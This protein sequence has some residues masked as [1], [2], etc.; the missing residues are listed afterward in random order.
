MAV[1]T[2]GKTALPR[3]AE[4]HR[5]TPA[6]SPRAGAVVTSLLCPSK[7][8]RPQRSSFDTRKTGTLLEGLGGS[9]DRR[10]LSSRVCEEKTDPEIN[11]NFFMKEETKT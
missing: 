1:R 9:P 6:Q 4:R 11:T 10:P 7:T 8:A 2:S 5:A 3:V